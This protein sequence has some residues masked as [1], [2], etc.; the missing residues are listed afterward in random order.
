MTKA[1]SLFKI[2]FFTCSIILFFASCA[3]SLKGIAI[4]DHAMTVK[5]SNGNTATSGLVPGSAYTV[6]LEF[7]RAEPKGTQDPWIRNPEPSEIRLTSPDR[8]IRVIN[9]NTISPVPFTFALTQNP[10][11]SL[12]VFLSQNPYTIPRQTY[13]VRWSSEG[14]FMLRGA[15][16]SERNNASGGH[17]S[18]GSSVTLQAAW[19]DVSGMN[20]SEPGPY[21]LIHSPS[22][23]RYMLVAAA[24]LPV[25]IDTRGGNGARGADGEDK[26][27]K[28]GQKEVYGEDG[29]NGGDG[30]D[31]GNVTI[32]FPEGHSAY[33]SLFQIRQEGGLAGS[34]GKA[35][36]GDKAKAAK[37]LTGFFDAL[38]GE[39]TGTPGSDGRPG[40]DGRTEYQ[41]R[42]LDLM[43]L[44]LN[45]PLFD[46]AR[47]RSARPAE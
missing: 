46:R 40:R 41:E 9:E 39:N 30:G 28:E 3:T 43:F 8:S 18:H 16:G 6:S 44:D 29:Y 19:Y 1:I 22:Q 38:L 11:F 7:L 13:P 12:E 32:I 37:G 2:L 10:V 15:S 31:G 17:G 36:Q 26:K 33:K 21:L 35:G 24:T 47:L 25:R 27:V 23:N 34:G 42:A 20:M 4:A 45:D 5:D 14:L